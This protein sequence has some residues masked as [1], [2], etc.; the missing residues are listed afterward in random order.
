MI[1][2]ARGFQHELRQGNLTGKWSEP[3]ALADS[4]FQRTCSPFEVQAIVLALWGLHIISLRSLVASTRASS[5][6][7][8]PW[9]RSPP[10]LSATHWLPM[11]L[12][13]FSVPKGYPHGLAFCC[14]D[15]YRLLCDLAGKN[16]LQIEPV[17]AVSP[18]CQCINSDPII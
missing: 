16:S 12:V 11:F 9:S 17:S 2:M 7:R 10:A 14:Q 4:R 8:K 1:L 15:S 5:M 6:K 3:L 13:T 18:V